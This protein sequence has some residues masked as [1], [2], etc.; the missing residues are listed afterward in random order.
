MRRRLLAAAAILIAA[1]AV[2]SG[3]LWWPEGDVTSTGVESESVTDSD[4]VLFYVD[5]SGAIVATATGMSGVDRQGRTAW[6]L[7]TDEFSPMHAVCA[8]T[9]PAAVVSSDANGVNSPIAPDPAPLLLGGAELPA[10]M[11]AESGGKSSVVA[12]A[13]GSAVRLESDEEGAARWLVSGKD[14][15]VDDASASGVIVD[16]FETSS[17]DAAMAIVSGGKVVEQQPWALRN[18]V[19]KPVGPRRQWSSG[20]GCT[21]ESGRFWVNDD[22]GI[23]SRTQSPARLQTDVRIS[24]CAFTSRHLIVASY[25]DSPGG[26]TTVITV[27]ALDGSQLSRQRFADQEIRIAADAGSDRYVL[28]GDHKAVLHDEGKMRTMPEVAVAAFDERGELVTLDPQGT[29]SWGGQ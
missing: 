8:P 18:G 28:F 27:F 16:W 20:Y 23:Q 4:P 6:T 14:G 24:N 12:V 15:Q 22:T 11:T 29:V 13:T 1:A 3:W 19:W 17:H 5:H 10:E 26:A 25:S 21:S 7:A 9:C 2:F